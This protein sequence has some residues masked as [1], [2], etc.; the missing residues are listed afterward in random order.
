[1][2]QL[3]LHWFRLAVGVD[4]LFITEDLVVGF[5][6]KILLIIQQLSSN[7]LMFCIS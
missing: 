1:M 5:N 3:S 6:E 7:K 2:E 4:R